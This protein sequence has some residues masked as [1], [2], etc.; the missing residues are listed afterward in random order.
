MLVVAVV[1]IVAVMF[2]FVFVWLL[3]GCLKIPTKSA[4]ATDLSAHST[5]NSA[6]A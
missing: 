2:D 3:T 5:T 1:A 6:G 4:L